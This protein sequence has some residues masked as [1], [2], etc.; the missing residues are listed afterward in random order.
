VKDS[1]ALR[2][3]M[4]RAEASLAAALAACGASV[5]ERLR[6]DGSTGPELLLAV[7]GLSAEALKDI[8]LALEE[9]SLWG[10]LIDADV[11]EVSGG[12]PLPLSRAERGQS[13]RACLVCER[14]A[15]E[16]IKEGRHGQEE[17]ED[18]ALRLLA[19]ALS[20]GQP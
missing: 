9:G 14:P 13:P 15:H 6:H 4:A 12:R 8:A 19:L 17:L 11:L 20:P 2:S 3:L 1:P 10:R 16:C 18:A 5:V 7:S